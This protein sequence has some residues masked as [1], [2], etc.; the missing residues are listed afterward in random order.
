[1][2][3]IRRQNR[4]AFVLSQAGFEF[5]KGRTMRG[6]TIEEATIMILDR[7]ANVL[8]LQEEE[9]F[10]RGFRRGQETRAEHCRATRAELACENLSADLGFAA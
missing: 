10:G 6:R 9:T 7:S 2:C 5:E 4:E 1:M 3:C 8:A